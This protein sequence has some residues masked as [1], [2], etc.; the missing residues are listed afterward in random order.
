[1]KGMHHTALFKD[2]N[3]LQTPQGLL[4]GILVLVVLWLLMRLA[5]RIFAGS[6]GQLIRAVRR[7]LVIGLAVA[8]LADWV[9][10]LIARN[11]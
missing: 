6:I 2:A 5:E 9:F 10:S 3:F 1:M 11:I 4:T 8:A 7:P